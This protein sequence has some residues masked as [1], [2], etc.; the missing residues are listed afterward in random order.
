MDGKAYSRKCYNAPECES[1]PYATETE[2]D[3]L[4]LFVGQRFLYLY[5]FGDEWRFEITVR[6]IRDEPYEGEPKVI[7]REG[8]P[9][10]PYPRYE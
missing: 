7:A 3:D 8:E 5:D 1:G 6:E 10:E 2:I 9:P 4:D